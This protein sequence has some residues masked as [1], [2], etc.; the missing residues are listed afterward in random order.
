METYIDAIDGLPRVAIGHVLDVLATLPEQSVH[1]CVTSPPY[2]GLRN[3]KTPPQIWDGDPKCTH[4]WAQDIRKVSGKVGHGRGGSTLSGGHESWGNRE[5]TTSGAFCTCCSAWRG[6]LGNEPTLDLYVAHMVAIFR[7][8]MRVLRDD[9]TLFLNIGDTYASA[10]PC[11]RRN[12]IGEGS[13]PNGKREARPPRMPHGL[14]EKDLVGIPWRVAFALQADGWY[15]RSDIV[16]EKP[17]V[18]PESATDRPTKSHEYIF[19]LSKSADYFFDMEAVRE[20]CVSGPSDLKKMREALPRIGGKHK[21]LDDA[22]SKANADTNIGQKRSVGDPTGRNIRSVWT[23]ATEP[24]RDAHFAAFPQ[25][26]PRRAIRAGTSE[27]GCCPTCGAPWAREVE[28]RSTCAVPRGTVPSSSRAIGQPQQA[29]VSVEVRTLGWQ[30][31]CGCPQHDPIP[32]TVLDIFAGSGTTL[33]VAEDLGRL[34]FGIDLS[35][36][37]LKL[38]KKRTAQRTVRGLFGRLDAKKVAAVKSAGRHIG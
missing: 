5:G 10:W 25:E 4:E 1:C 27:R 37:Y 15:L 26:I 28:R 16:W 19:L 2:W 18:M 6:H 24:Y 17:N 35:D 22:L 12:V 11:Q 8:V 36:E 23:I 14:K 32:C 20:P 30:P 21:S 31:T 9:G 33:Q 7:A 3:Y 38:I 29:G 34:W 13:L